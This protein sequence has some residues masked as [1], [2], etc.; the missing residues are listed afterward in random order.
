M[1]L[2]PGFLIGVC[3]VKPCIVD[4]DDLVSRLA[5]VGENT[6]QSANQSN[7]ADRKA[8][9]FLNFPDDGIDTP[10]AEFN[11]AANGAKERALFDGI[12]ESVDQYFS[13]VVKDAQSEGAYAVFRH[14]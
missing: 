2:Q 10:F 14:E 1:A 6:F 8:Q 3:V 5:R 11:A 12:G 7:V 4:L 13:V 9:F